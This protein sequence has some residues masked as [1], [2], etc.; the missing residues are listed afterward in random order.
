MALNGIM[1][2]SR[3]MA[4]DLVEGLVATRPWRGLYR[5]RF[6]QDDEGESFWIVQSGFVYQT[7]QEGGRH[8]PSILTLVP[9]LPPEVAKA[10]TAAPITQPWSFSSSKDRDLLCIRSQA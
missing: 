4:K 5:R 6:R 1:R 9:D 3:A 8:S 10:L 2:V 7:V